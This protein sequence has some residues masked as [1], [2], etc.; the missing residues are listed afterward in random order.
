[1]DYKKNSPIEAVF[2]FLLEVVDRGYSHIELMSHLTYT[3][4]RMNK[5]Q[6]EESPVVL[7]ILDGFG[8]AD[9]K[10]PGNAITP[11]TAPAIFSYM[12][13]YPSTTLTAHGKSVGLFPNQEGNSEAGHLTIGAGRVVKQDLVIISDAIKDG[14]FFKN[15]S[16]HQAVEHTKKYKSRLHVMGLLTDGQSAH[17]HND[18]LYAVLDYARRMEVKEVFLHLFTDGRDASPHGAVTFLR[19]LQKHMTEGQYIASVTGRFYAMDRS[20]TWG[21]TEHA[22]N[23]LVLGKGCFAASPEE[24]IDQGYNRG[25]TDE[26]ILPTI[27]MNGKKP[28]ATIKNDDAILFFN[29]RSDRARQITKTFVQKNFTKQNPGAFVRKKTLKN[30][31]FVAM[32]DFGPDLPG[33]RIAFPSP[34]IDNCLAKAVGDAR[35]QLYISEMEKFAHVTFF[36]NGGYPEPI[37]GEKREVVPSLQEYSFTKRPQMNAREV[38]K[39][40]LRYLK[41]NTYNFI[42][43]NYP[44]ADMLGHTGNMSAAKKAIHIVDKEVKNIVDCV[45]AKHGTVVITADHGNAESMIGDTDQEM[46][47]EHSTNP[48]PFILVSKTYR[49]VRMKKGTLAD[50]APTMLKIMQLPSPKEMTGK[51]L[52]K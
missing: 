11:K 17:A 15:E 24:A 20:K 10:S 39:R 25:E 2:L 4:H 38:T 13:K 22:Y 26:Y 18:H 45:L 28:V 1:M 37:Y 47:T 32:T 49:H 44:N 29:A 6:R 31:C 40:I 5:K 43:V 14:T 52:F 8:L 23:A 27:I 48:V 33:M 34:D 7:I 51:G 50:V 41:Q 9:I 21:R 3:T 16:F 12:K 19:Q 36:I 30:I 46:L 35:R 42:V